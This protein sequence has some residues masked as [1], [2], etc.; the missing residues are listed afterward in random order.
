MFIGLVSGCTS[1]H[2]RD[3]APQNAELF[4]VVSVETPSRIMVRDGFRK[5]VVDLAYYIPETDKCKLDVCALLSDRVLNKKVWVQ[6]IYERYGLAMHAVWLDDAYDNDVIY[7]INIALLMEGYDGATVDYHALPDGKSYMISMAKE[8]GMNKK[9]L[10]K[11]EN[12]MPQWRLNTLQ[13]VREQE[14]LK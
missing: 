14:L 5:Y 11:I 1:V 13:D 10:K 6:K 8:I 3:P 2:H 7:P 4:T 12:S 9:R